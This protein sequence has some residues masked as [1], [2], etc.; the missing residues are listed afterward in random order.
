MMADAI[1]ARPPAGGA[2]PAATPQMTVGDLGKQQLETLRGSWK[3][4]IRYL[5]AEGNRKT[6]TGV[7]QGLAA[8]DNGS[9]ILYRDIKA[10]GAEGVYDG[11]ALLTYDPGQG[12]FLET[13]FS[14]TD[15]IVKSVGEYLPDKNSYNF[16]VVQGEGGEMVQG[17]IMR[18]SVRVEIR[19]SGPA[20]FVAETF[21]L[22]EGQ[23]VQVQSYRFTR[24]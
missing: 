4:D 11:Y 23:E 3:L 16:Y 13:S 9:R 21:T 1:A 10:E 24:S 6:A 15:E 22:I 19:V 2:T 17:G 7:A 8:G 14:T 5:D 12:F 20:M 18:S